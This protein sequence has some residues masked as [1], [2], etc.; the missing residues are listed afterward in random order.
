MR[1][2]SV[3]DILPAFIGIVLLAL[4]GMMSDRPKAQNIDTYSSYDARSGGYRAWYELLER[5]GVPVTRFERHWAFLD[6]SLKTLIVAFPLPFSPLHGASI[7]RTDRAALT[8]WVAEGGTLIA[9]GTFTP[10][11]DSPF[12]EIRYRALSPDALRAM[13]VQ[14]RAGKFPVVLR[15]RYLRGA[16]L[17]IDDQTLF[18]NENIARADNA[19]LAYALGSLP[20]AGA[21]AF[22]ETLHGYLIPEHWWLIAPQRLLVALAIAGIVVL[23]ALGGAAIRLGPPISSPSRREPTSWE[24]VHAVAS[25]YARTGARR[26]VLHLALNSAKRSASS[27]AELTELEDLAALPAPDE[28]ALVRG[29]ALAHRLRFLSPFGQG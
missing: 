27:G 22:D 6:S 28:R 23:I 15:G 16:I 19:R 18:D 21:V 9:L 24:Y 4:F 20:R 5:E 7:A 26:K 17:R 11:P 8:A 1:R 25:L 12:A 14:P 29:V 13:G 2:I 3:L 10:T